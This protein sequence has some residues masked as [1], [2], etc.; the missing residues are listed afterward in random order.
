MIPDESGGKTIKFSVLVAVYNAAPYLRA[1]LDSILHQSVDDLQIL[2]VDD[3]STDDSLSILS[4][5]AARDERVEVIRLDQ[6]QGQA[7]ARNVALSRAKGE[8]VLMVDA[9][10]LLGEDALAEIERTIK[11]FPSADCIVLQLVRF[12]AAQATEREDGAAPDTTFTGEE[13]CKAAINWALNGLY[14]GRRDLYQRMP[15]DASSRV[16]SDDNTSR[17]HYLLSRQVAV[18]AG[19]YLY[20]QHEASATHRFDLRRLDFLAANRSLR[21]LLEQHQAN[22]DILTACEEHCWRNFVGLY[23]Q[24]RRHWSAFSPQAHQQIRDAFKASLQAMHPER[25]PRGLRW[26]P[27]WLFVRPF[28]LFVAYRQV[29]RVLKILKPF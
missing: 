21:S 13:A 15:F 14:A 19:E 16:Y 5:Y 28:S 4:E 2:C 29:L 6:N 18:S 26:S 8:W 25:L 1:C 23:L 12:G 17:I 27:S 22:A 7:A 3:A 9:D 20:R 11:R 24:F 10:D